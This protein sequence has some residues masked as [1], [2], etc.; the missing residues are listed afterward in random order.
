MRVLTAAQMRE[1][2]RLTT[3]RYGI[4]SVL[5]MEN[6]ARQI[7]RAVEARLG[8]V[9]GRRILVVCGK[10]NNGGDGA[11]FARLA[12]MS[13]ARVDV[14]LLSSLDKTTG[15]ARINFDIVK[16]LAVAT[17]RLT[18]TEATDATAWRP[19]REQLKHYAL[20]V[21]GILG[22]GIERPADGLYAEVIRDLAALFEEPARTVRIVAVDLPSGLPTDVD[23]PLGPTVSADLTVTFTAP[24]PAN[25]LPPACYYGGELVVAPI[26]SP[27]ELIESVGPTLTLLESEMI[28]AWLCRTRRLP[29]SHKGTYGHVFLIAGSRGK[30]GAA[31]LAAQAALRSGAGLVTVGTPASCHSL[32]ISHVAE[33]MTEPLQETPEGSLAHTALER[34]LQLAGERDVLALGPGITTVEST[35]RF[36]H[37]LLRRRTVPAI[38]DADGLNCLAPW[39]DDITGQD[40]PLIVTPHPGE[41]AR[42]MGV[43]IQDVLHHRV[44][45]AR[46]FATE[47]SLILVLK[48]NRTLIASADGHV[49][50]NPTGNPGMATA[51]SGDVLTGILA[52]CLAQDRNS[53]L[54]ATLAAVYLHGLAGDLAARTLG[55]RALIA[56]DITAHVGAALR[57]VVEE[58]SDDSFSRRGERIW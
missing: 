29:T 35:R 55:T 45:V 4:P 53:P 41:M 22:T 9:A 26:G 23:R 17:S 33:A 19:F 12:W 56:S 43:S 47:H 2:D 32:I 51:G 8:P 20:V 52:G 50:I 6:A 1:V 15:D 58:N 14:A 57:A 25:V 54:D 11:A 13:G 38:V 49:Y 40:V 21:D 30:P 36:V 18:F 16:K 34:A 42:L 10:G 3:E 46:R 28:A 44:E 48:G 5:L 7:L 31:C 37:D 39:P 27:Q 24:K